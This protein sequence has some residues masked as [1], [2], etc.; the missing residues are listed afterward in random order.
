MVRVAEN[1]PIATRKPGKTYRFVVTDL[2]GK[3]LNLGSANFK[4]A[5]LWV[6]LSTD[7]PLDILPANFTNVSWSDAIAVG[8]LVVRYDVRS[9][10]AA[11]VRNAKVTAA[12]DVALTA[13]ES[14]AILATDLSVVK[15]EGG[16]VFG[17]N[18]NSVAVNGLIATNVVLS[19]A[20]SFITG[21][22]IPTTD[23]RDLDLVADNTSSIIADITSKTTSNSIS[24]GT[25]L[26]LNTIGWESQNILFNTV[27]VLFGTDIGTETPA[28]VRAFLED[29][30]VHAAGAISLSATF[31]A[32]LDASVGNS[33]TAIVANVGSDTKG[34]SVVAVLAMN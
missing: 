13:L 32:T 33:A 18:G 23:G 9:D 20:N 14:A 28:Q 34:I 15:S 31:N 5:A 12:S 3:A 4:N 11:F 1:Y 19:A 17:E 26:A 22:D 7:N 16:S 30:E 2:Q 24:V 6:E 25:T 27:D 10:V 8:G 21:S 29:T